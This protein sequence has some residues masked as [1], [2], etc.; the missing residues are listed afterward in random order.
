MPQMRRHQS[1]V[2]ATAQPRAVTAHAGCSHSHGVGRA[3][4]CADNNRAGCLGLSVLRRAYASC[5]CVTSRPCSALC[6]YALPAHLTERARGAAAVLRVLWAVP[7]GQAP[8]LRQLQRVRR[9]APSVLLVAT[10]HGLGRGATRAR[11]CSRGSFC[12]VDLWGWVC[13]LPQLCQSPRRSTR[14]LVRAG[15]SHSSAQRAFACTNRCASRVFSVTHTS[16]AMQHV[17]VCHPLVL[18]AVH[19]YTS[20]Q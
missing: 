15:G 18:L 5:W 9:A 17:S 2:C 4:V 16:G 11:R 14:L 13:E 3:G 1:R 20:Q 12:R 7:D 6:R 10:V 19:Q 8:P